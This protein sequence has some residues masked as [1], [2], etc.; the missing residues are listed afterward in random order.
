MSNLIKYA[1][2]FNDAFEVDVP[3]DMEYGVSTEWDSIGHMSLI[4][5]IEDTFSISFE[6]DDIINFSSFRKGLEILSNNYKVV[7]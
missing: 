6:T 7:F 5:S 4:S 1:K 2:C 3:E